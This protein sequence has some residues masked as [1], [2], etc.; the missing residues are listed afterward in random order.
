[1]IR[2]A[3]PEDIPAVSAIYSRIH[4]REEAGLA[5]IGW[6]RSIYPTEATA[7]SAL[8]AGDLFVREEA[9]R[10]LA[11]ARI[12]S[13]QV[14]E[15]ALADWLY[16]APEEHVMVLHTLCVDP[17]HAGKGVGKDFVAFYERYALRKGCRNLRLDT[18]ERNT[19]ARRLYRAL[20]YREAGIVPCRFNGIPGV[21]LV[22]LDKY[23]SPE[24]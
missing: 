11:S 6:V 24:E 4:D 13:V 3:V 1:M 14:P 10:I 9:G 7:R 2:L 18:N 20:G 5:T 15:Y 23:L 8:A 19:A 17:L 16:E 12:N 22:C 21:R